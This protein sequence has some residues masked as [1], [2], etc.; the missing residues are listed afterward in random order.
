LTGTLVLLLGFGFRVGAVLGANLIAISVVAIAIAVAAV[1]FHGLVFNRALFARVFRFTLPLSFSALAL[2][3]IHFGDRFVLARYRA[4]ADVGIYAVAYKLGMLLGPVQ[5]AFE[6]YWASQIYQI[7]KREDA[8]MVFART[9]TYLVLVISFAGL[10]IL[11]A[12]KPALRIFTPPSY[13]AAAALVP[14]I[15]LAYFLRAVG[16][17]FRILFLAHGL[18]TH[19]AA[20]NW[21]AAI[22]AIAGYLILIPRYGMFGAAIATLIT[23]IGAATLS[24]LWTFRVWH[25]HVEWGR[26]C[27]LI[28][29]LAGL[30]A[31]HFALGPASNT[32]E[33]VRGILII[34][35]YA[36]LLWFLQFAS[37]GE[38]QLIRAA[39]GR[40]AP[41]ILTR[42]P[43]V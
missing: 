25:F 40:F 8:R 14:I 32:V 9:F 38:K 20:C 36:P 13:F 16:D 28:A 11:V 10:G 34:A 26:L 4:L 15:L 23:F 33:I 31:I 27:K 37:P 3:L 1:R 35:A 42:S 21:I 29:V 12:T 6:A 17:Y 39:A 7:I 19:D 22:C 24:I 18:S 43:E 30:V 5:A 2:F 41:W